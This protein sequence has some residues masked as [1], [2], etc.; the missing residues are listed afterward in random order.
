MKTRTGVIYHRRQND[1]NN[2]LSTYITHISSKTC[3]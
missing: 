2:V 1:R 3:I